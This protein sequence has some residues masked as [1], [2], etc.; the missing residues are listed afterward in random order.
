MY[1]QKGI[2]CSD[3]PAKSTTEEKRWFYLWLSREERKTAFSAW[4]SCRQWS[5][6]WT[7]DYDLRSEP[8]V[9]EFFDYNVGM[10]LKSA[11]LCNGEKG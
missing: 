2:R 8:L 10:G 11:D 1:K 4:R 7:M 6:I 9:G 5:M 3:A